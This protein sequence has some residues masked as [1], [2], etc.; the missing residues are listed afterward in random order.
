MSLLRAFWEE[1]GDRRGGR[2]RDRT[3]RC[4]QLFG[5]H[6]R[7]FKRRLRPASSTFTGK[8]SLKCLSGHPP[9][10]SFSKMLRLDL[11]PLPGMS[12]PFYLLG[13]ALIGVVRSARR[14]PTSVTVHPVALFSILDHYLRRTDAQDRVIGTLLGTRSDTGEVEVRSSFAVL[15]SETADQVAVDMEYHRTMFDLHHKVSPKEV[16]VGWYAPISPLSV[17]AMC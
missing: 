7:F 12:T 9:P 3:G 6:G 17:C 2:G 8:T 4:R 13:R 10:P 15:H 14:T 5:R 11:H 16:I 1:D